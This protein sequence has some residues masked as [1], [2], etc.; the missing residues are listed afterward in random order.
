MITRYPRKPALIVVLL[1]LAVG[2][3]Y[4]KAWGRIER[5]WTK[6]PG[7]Q[8]VEALEKRVAQ[9]G[10]SGKVSIA[11]WTAYADAL[12]DAKQYAK[13]A[14]AYREVLAIDPTQRGA[15]FQVG[16]ALA[17]AGAAEEFYNYQKDL[18]YGEPKLAVELFER[19][20]AQ[21]F[22]SEERFAALSKEAK[23]QAMD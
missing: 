2:V 20:E 18:V 13:A 21:K 11:T 8:S 9:E 12:S 16:L 5:L 7:E 6:Q 23:N 14:S 1:A 22:M 19:P 15:K 17:Q 3:F 10:K 4:V